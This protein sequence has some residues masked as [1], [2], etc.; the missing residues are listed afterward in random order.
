[1]KYSSLCVLAYKRP[2]MLKQCIES[3][4]ATADLPYELI[5][6]LDGD[7]SGNAEYLFQLYKDKKISYLILNAGN[8]RGV[9]RSM[10]NCLGVAEGDYTFKIDTDLIF[11]PQWLSKAVEIL[12]NFPVVGAVS[13]FNYRNYD[14]KDERFQVTNALATCNFVNDF[15]SSVYGFKSETMLRAGAPLY[16]DGYHQHLK[17]LGYEL[18]ITKDD[19]VTNNGFGV[20]KSTYVSGTEE[21]PFKT[22]THDTPLIFKSG[23]N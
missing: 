8:N 12:D 19:Y 23:L 18:A 4:I 22:P 9:G 20:Y 2:E 11:K 13:L 6:N 3:I 14:A 21:N 7:D 15:V 16:D 5:V 10:A 1:M 17:E